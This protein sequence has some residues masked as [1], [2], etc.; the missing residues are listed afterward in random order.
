[1][2][3]FFSIFKSA[4][5]LNVAVD[6]N[7]GQ[8]KTIVMLHGIAAS[9]ETWQPVIPKIDSS[10]YRVIAIDLLGFG[11][12]PKPKD[13]KYTVDDH[14]KSVRRTLKHLRIHTPIQL[15]GHSM[16][17][18]IAMRYYHKHP[19]DIT[20]IHLLSPPI[21]HKKEINK[22]HVARL[23]TDLYFEFY[24]FLTTNKDFTLTASRHIR[25][26]L[27]LKDSADVTEET[28][29]SFRLSLK[30][31]IIHQQ[32]YDDIRQARVPIYITYGVLDEFLV[33]KNI[34]TLARYKH[35]NITK[36]QAVD[37]IVTPRF[38]TKV[39]NQID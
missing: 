31:T 22:R 36:L 6:T 11:E 38:A 28:W 15:M 16:G 12:S 17:S 24:H 26:L 29:E 8:R 33:A 9:S 32:T 19:Q 18:I 3:S 7:N 23:K 5:L 25:K 14:V 35:V 20:A 34:D 37:H 10:K 27:R 13:C 2:K 30:N 39:V 21:Y 1:M 4:P